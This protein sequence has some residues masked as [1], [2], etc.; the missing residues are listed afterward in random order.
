M[1]IETLTTDAIEQQLLAIEAMIAKGRAAQMTLLGE[2]D[3]RQVH[4]A[5]GCRDLVEWAASRLDLRSDTARKLV[6]TARRLETLPNAYQAARR[7]RVSVDRI[8]ATAKV[9]A[10]GGGDTDLVD[11]CFRY[12]VDGLSRFGAR[13][14]SVTRDDERE[15]FRR[16]WLYVQPILDDS[17]WHLSGCLAGAAGKIVVD[18]LEAKV[19]A[20]PNE[21]FEWRS[22]R[23][24]DALWQISFD[25]LT[26]GSDGGSVE[27]ATPLLTVFL[28]ASEAAPSNG[29]AGAWIP[30][31]PRVERDTLDA[32]FCDGVV[33]V[34]AKIAGGEAVSMG[35]RTRVI[36][37]RLRRF[38]LA[39]DDGC[40]I[41]GCTSR[42]RLQVHHIVSWSD[43]GPTDVS[44]LATVCWFHHHVVIHGRFFTIDPH[45]PAYRR[46]LPPPIHAP[47]RE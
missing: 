30:A 4:T 8:W 15:A 32:I 1:K 18:A 14:R 21:P 41:A 37:P 12:S 33:E 17:L 10:P 46:R 19:D 3:R 47:P 26:K 23:R 24:A 5:D 44:N 35:R 6:T 40:V 42:Y 2:I 36:P 22:S 34:T 16:R 7:G 25:S 28:D 27:T 9:A 11:N 13:R 20:M 29:E 31:G 43:G 45:S 39:R 38:V